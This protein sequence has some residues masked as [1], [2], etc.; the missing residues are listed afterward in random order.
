MHRLALLL[1]ALA[2][3]ALVSAAAADTSIPP[4]PG[5]ELNG[6]GPS[7]DTAGVPDASGS[8]YRQS[9]NPKYDVA[10]SGAAVVSEQTVAPRLASTPL[11]VACKSKTV[12]V[13]AKNLLGATLY[14]FFMSKRWCFDGRRVYEPHSSAWACCLFPTIDLKSKW[15]DG[16]Y[17]TWG[18]RRR[19]GHFSYRAA[20]LQACVPFVGCV[21]TYLPRINIWVHANGTW[22]YSYRAY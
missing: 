15:G 17:Y 16:W 6:R 7:N 1:A 19:G 22:A 10:T 5:E 13:Y 20:K 12:Y 8:S 3:L 21:Q 2:A 14:K 9:G 18:G 11:S 4:R